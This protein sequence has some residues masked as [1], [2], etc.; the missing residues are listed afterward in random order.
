MWLWTVLY[1]MVIKRNKLKDTDSNGL[2]RDLFEEKQ[3]GKREGGDKDG[4]WKIERSW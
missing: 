2:D 3:K 4:V 1:S